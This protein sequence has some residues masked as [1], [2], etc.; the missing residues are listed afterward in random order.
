M[1]KK[2]LRDTII[3]GASAVLPRLINYAFLK[4]FT[5]VLDKKAFSL[6]T[7][8]YALSFLLISVLTFGLESAYFRFLYKG[9]NIDRNKVFSSAMI[10]L[11][12]IGLNFLVFGIL[13]IK[14][15]SYV[16]G[17]SNHQ[18]YLWMF[19]LIIFFD[20]ISS[21]PMAWLR[22]Q[23]RA[24]RYAFV[25]V[26]N[27][28]IQALVTFWLLN[29]PTEFSWDFLNFSE[30]IKSYTDKTGCIFYAN[31][32]A[33]MVGFIC[34]LDILIKIRLKKFR[35]KIALKMLAY[36][37]PIMLGTLAFAL[38]ENLDKI[39]I[40]RWIS[41]E[42]NGAY[43]ACYK[44]AAFMALYST[45][46]RLGIEP[47]YFKKAKDA[48]AKRIYSELTYLFTLF[49]TVFFVLLWSN[50][51]WMG[52]FMIGNYYQSA[53]NIIPIVMM[54]NLFLGIYINLS[55]AYKVKDQPIIGTYISLIGAL[56]TILFNL[57]L[58]LPEVNYMVSAWGTLASYGSMVVI[59]YWWGQK[60]YKV[61]YPLTRIFLH[62][63]LGI[64]A[65]YLLGEKMKNYNIIG[66]LL[67]LCMVF[68]IEKSKLIKILHG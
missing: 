11:L 17:Y 13:F 54:A 1:Y 8:M 62:L 24:L 5:N 25:R 51:N 34:L 18:E 68:F 21:I 52:P 42:I 22:M 4:L 37:T 36:G 45:A 31:M 43:A 57:L 61:N 64:I 29:E 26:V 15:I 27:V 41:D 59:S 3:Y 16:L 7:D 14:E 47:F 40:K 44:I 49:G 50:L 58:L 23:R 35:L 53:R 46:F 32:I 20:V 19:I 56:I 12:F 6:Y 9:K 33:S 67:Y 66:Q 39:L 48:D 30:Y 55:I 28:F 38:N 10:S 2:I 65:G 60:N 63:A